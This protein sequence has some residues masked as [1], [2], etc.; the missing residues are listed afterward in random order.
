MILWFCFA[1]FDFDCVYLWTETLLSLWFSYFFNIESFILCCILCCVIPF[2]RYWSNSLEVSVTIMSVALFWESL[3]VCC[4]PIQCSL[5]DSV[6]TYCHNI[7]CYLTHK[8]AFIY[9]YIYI[10]IILVA[11]FWEWMSILCV[12]LV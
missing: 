4:R 1:L 12:I 3:S 5:S 8:M 2:L 7:L 10:T 11:S 6:F 9:I